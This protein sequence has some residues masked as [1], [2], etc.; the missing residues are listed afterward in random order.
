MGLL[1]PRGAFA[2]DQEVSSD[3][4]SQ[5]CK[6]LQDVC[7]GLKVSSFDQFKS[8]SSQQQGSLRQTFV[9]F[10]SELLRVNTHTHTH[11]CLFEV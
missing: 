6:G 1:K 8:P 11:T 10:G 9:S 4:G 7:G 5:L 3:L 2:C